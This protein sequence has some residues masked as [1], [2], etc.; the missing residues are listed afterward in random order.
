[1]F[2]RAR[3]VLVAVSGLVVVVSVVVVVTSQT[4]SRSTHSPGWKQADLDRNSLDLGLFRMREAADGPGL[5]THEFE[6]RDLAGAVR[7]G[8]VVKAG[9]AARLRH[10]GDLFVLV[11]Y[12][13]G[14]ADEFGS[15]P[16]V[17]CWRFTT[18]DGYDVGF[19][20]V[21]CP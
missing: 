19:D 11:R 7:H 6:G 14:S 8:T 2:T 17:E 10:G 16:D 5:L 20:R 15:E 12:D 18:P 3:L 9:G 21:D 13:F 4:G 1:M